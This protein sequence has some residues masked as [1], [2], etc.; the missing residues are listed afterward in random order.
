MC[1]WNYTPTS[2]KPSR[3]V[4]PSFVPCNRRVSTHATGQ[5]LH[6][7]EHRR[8]DLVPVGND[9]LA[10]DADPM[11]GEP[12]DTGMPGECSA[13]TQVCDGGSLVCE[14]SGSAVPETC[15]AHDDDCVGTPD[16]GNS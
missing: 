14:P 7:L 3:N 8:V 15:H 6:V 12:C 2:P 1:L 9:L 16:N 10:L 13:G 5:G 11:L 4:P